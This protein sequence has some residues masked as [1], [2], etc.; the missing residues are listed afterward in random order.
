MRKKQ[1]F[2]LTVNGEQREVWV[3]RTLEDAARR[4]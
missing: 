4:M 1:L 3:R 2:Q